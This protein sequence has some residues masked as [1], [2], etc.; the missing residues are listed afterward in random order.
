MQ[1]AGRMPDTTIEVPLYLDGREVA[2]ATAY[3]MGV[4][5]AWE[6]M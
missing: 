2:R 5:M 6:E 1:M 4:Q 3:Q